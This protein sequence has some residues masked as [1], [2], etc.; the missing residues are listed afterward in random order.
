MTKRSQFRKAAAPLGVALALLIAAIPAFAA[1]APAKPASPTTPV[2][3]TQDWWQARHASMNARV[4]Q[5]NVDLLFI[6]DSITHGWEGGGKDTWDKYYG[7]RNAVNLGIGGD[8]T[9]HVL[10][11]LDNGNIDG[12]TP[13]LAVVMIG[14]NNSGDNTAEEIG[15]GVTAVVTKLRQ[16]LPNTKVLLLAIFPREEKPGEL[17]AKNAKASEIASKIADGKNVFFLDIG[18]EFLTSDG[19][20]PKPIMPDALHPNEAGYVLWAAAIEP[21]VAELLGETAAGKPLKGFEPLFDGKT[22]AG[23]KGLVTDPVK[24]AAMKPEELAAAQAKADESMRAHWSVV[25]GILNFDGKGEALCTGRDYEDFEMTVDWKIEKDGDSGIYLRGS[26]QVQIWDPASKPANGIGSGGL[27]NNKKGAHDPLV[28]ADNPIGQWNRFR[29]KMIGEKVNVWLNG[30]LVVDNV[31]LE[32]YWDSTKP[33]YASGQIELQNHGSHLWFKNI[34]IREIPRGEGWVDLFNGKDLA[35]WEQVGGD[36]QTWHVADGILYT[37]GGGGGWL[38]S[39]KEYADFDLSLEFRVPVN[40]N[41]GVFIRAPREGNPAFAG[42]EIQ[43]LDD[44]GSDYTKLEPWQYCGSVYSTVAPS[45]RVT[46]PAGE[47][48]SMRIHAEGPK[49]SVVLNGFPIIDA[50]LNEHL[51]GLEKH[52]G[53]KRTAGFIGLQD[54]SSR[55]DYRNIRILD[56]K[57]IPAPP[58]APAA[59]P[60]PAKAPAAAPAPAPA[61]K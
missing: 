57:P 34:Y 13:K 30:K 44:F 24:R 37:D 21:T 14:T 29:I 46:R 49:V 17:R 39:K 16:K 23:W 40:G 4:K 10:W 27:Y 25:D 45:R 58:P 18:G 22:L 61:G 56:L 47:W 7:D 2:P 20:I 32:N 1:D 55:V 52:P 59:A 5:G 19:T 28:K 43:V 3:R 42:S 8:R 26:P 50:N 11:R 31:A 35:G 36:K 41:S 15:A 33:I 38:S 48:Q 60:A 9:E 54:H 51:E 12:I 53:L 6:G